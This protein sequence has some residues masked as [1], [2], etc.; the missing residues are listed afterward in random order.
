MIRL[1]LVLLLTSLITPSAFSQK[2]QVDKEAKGLKGNVKNVDR[3]I[4]L[5]DRSSGEPESTRQRAGTEEFDA[6][7]N[8]T[9]EKYYDP[10]GDVLALL[11]YSF[12]D[13]ERVVKREF[14]S[15]RVMVLR[16]PGDEPTR[17]ADPRYTAKLKHKYDSN[18]NRIESTWIYSDGSRSTKQVYTFR[19]NEREEL[20]YSAESLTAKY[21]YKLD[22]KGNE[23]EKLAIEY[24]SPRGPL[25]G[26]TK[27]TY[28]E[29]DSQ[30]NWIKRR[31]SSGD[32]SWIIYRTITYH[33]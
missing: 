10:F 20:L 23:L 13:G 2:Q 8:L 15:K 33:R 16:R 26:K 9:V 12:L 3:H 19:E 31:E 17:T 1:F 7:G 6:D 29:F 11:T 28:L 5:I 25:Q 22:D 18:G 4:S 30:G 21:V 27:Y 24:E 14:K 32:Q